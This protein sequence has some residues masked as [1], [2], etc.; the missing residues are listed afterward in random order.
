MPATESGPNDDE[1]PEAR[2]KI[3]REEIKRRLSTADLSNVRIENVLDT[4]KPFTYSYH[5]RVPNY[6]Q[7]T[8]KRLFLQPNFFTQ[9]LSVI[10]TASVAKTISTFVMRGLSQI[11]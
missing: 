7:R 2:E 3:L 10:L 4:I 1:S 8:A 11:T 5:V 9:G 6:A